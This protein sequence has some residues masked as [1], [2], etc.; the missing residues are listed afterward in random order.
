MALSE[1]DQKVIEAFR[2][3]LENSLSAEDGI[4]AI[5]RHDHPDGSTLATRFELAA[6]VWLELAIRPVALQLQ[7]SILTDDRWLSEEME[8]AIE[9]S[10]DTMGEFVEMGFDEQGLDWEDPP[11]LHYRDASKCFY[12]STP[13]DIE[14]LGVLAEESVRIRSRQMV[15][16]YRCAFTSILAKSE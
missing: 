15:L 10:G 16:G 7:A 13:R 5:E 12:F 2:E 8:T 4:G 1:Q 14:S 3:W 6:H 9:D 11:V